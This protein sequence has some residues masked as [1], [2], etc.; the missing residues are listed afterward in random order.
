MRGIYV[1]NVSTNE[2]KI[3]LKLPFVNTP[4]NRWVNYR[5]QQGIY[6]VRLISLFHPAKAGRDATLFETLPH[7]AECGM[8]LNKLL[9]C[10]SITTMNSEIMLVL[11]RLRHLKIHLSAL[12]NTTA[13]ADERSTIWPRCRQAHAPR[14]QAL[15]VFH[16]QSLRITTS[17]RRSQRGHTAC[18][19]EHFAS[20][21]RT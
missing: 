17:Q 10:G 15:D 1:V 20:I 6:C 18:Q 14:L 4:E 3:T 2:Q 8:L 21:P 19:I 16:P 5:T 9:R 7:T 11:C 12:A 13:R